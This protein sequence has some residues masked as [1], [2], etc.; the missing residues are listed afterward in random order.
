MRFPAYFSLLS[1]FQFS[2]S[3]TN[4]LLL[5]FLITQKKSCLQRRGNC[6]DVADN[7]RRQVRLSWENDGV[8]GVLVPARLLDA[9]AQAHHASAVN[10]GT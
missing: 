7:Q 10:E 6:M 2:F 8:I 3:S 5:Q 9:S 4:H 1:S